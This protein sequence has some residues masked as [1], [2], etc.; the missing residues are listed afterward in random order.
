MAKGYLRQPRVDFDKVC[1]PIIARM[2]IV[3]LLLA[4]GAQ[5]KWP[6]FHF[7]VKSAILNGKY[8]KKFMLRN[9]RVIQ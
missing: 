4:L 2:E 8:T 7:D 5:M 1:S 6:A 3:R 9:Q